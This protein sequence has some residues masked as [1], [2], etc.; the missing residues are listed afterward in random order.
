MSP[1]NYAEN[2][3][4]KHIDLWGLQKIEK[5]LEPTVDGADA[6]FE[7]SEFVVRAF[8]HIPSSDF[9]V[10][11]GGEIVQRDAGYWEKMSESGVVNQFL[12]SIAEGVNVFGRSPLALG[13]CKNNK[14]W[15]LAPILRIV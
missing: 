7:I 15:T 8:R 13:L 11:D 5:Q 2:S 1:F 10:P 14:T 12:Y 6:H 3:P 9:Q 4:I